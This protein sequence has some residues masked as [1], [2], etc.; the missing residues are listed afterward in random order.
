MSLLLSSRR[1]EPSIAPGLNSRNGPTE[2][3]KETAT[4]SMVPVD[5]VL[6]TVTRSELITY[7]QSYAWELVLAH[8]QSTTAR[9]DLG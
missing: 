8:G 4:G 6:K 9:Q 1:Q 7:E 2:S 5:S 3:E